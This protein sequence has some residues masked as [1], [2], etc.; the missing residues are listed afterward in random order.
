MAPNRPQIFPFPGTP[1]T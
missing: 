1:S